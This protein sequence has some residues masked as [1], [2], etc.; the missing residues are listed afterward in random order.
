ML[1]FTVIS[2]PGFQGSLERPHARFDKDPIPEILGPWEALLVL[3]KP[4][5][6]LG[7]GRHCTRLVLELPVSGRH[8]GHSQ[9]SHLGLQL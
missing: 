7:G 3:G 5:A 2:E 6:R 4:R 1:G 8:R 9:L